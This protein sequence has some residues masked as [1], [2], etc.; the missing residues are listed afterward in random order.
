MTRRM[1]ALGSGTALTAGVAISKE[2]KARLLTVR[3]LFQLLAT[4][5]PLKLPLPVIVASVAR[6]LAAKLMLL[7]LTV[8]AS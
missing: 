4:T 1:R 6:M 3:E 8:V 5:V 2:E 7:R